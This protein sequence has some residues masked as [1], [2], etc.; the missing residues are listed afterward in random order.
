MFFNSIHY[1][2]FLP[3]V[4]AG[5]FLLPNKFRWGA[6]LAASY[7]FYMC[8]KIEYIILIV[9]S[10][11]VDYYAARAMGE[12]QEPSR[13][14]LLLTI[15]I[16][17]NLGILIAFKYFNFFSAST[18]ALFQHFNI[19]YDAPLFHVLLPVGISFYTFQTLSYTIE[20]YRGTQDP[21]KHLGIFALYVSFFP[22]LVAGPIERSTNLLP[23]FRESHS[24]NYDSAKSGAILIMWGLFKKVVVADRAAVIANHVFNNPGHYDGVQFAIGT[25][26]FAYQIYCD[27]SG[28]SDIAIGSAEI[29]GF[30]LMKNFDRPYYAKSIAEFWKRWHISL[31]TWFRDYLYIPLGGNRTNTVRR[32]ANLLITFII[33]GLW[34]GAAWTFVIWGALNGMYLILEVLARPMIVRIERY[35]R[36]NPDQ[37]AYKL[38]RVAITF[39]LTCFAWIFFRANNVSDAFYIVRRLDS[40]WRELFLAISSHNAAFINGLLRSLGLSKNE[41]LIT[42]GAIV[43][44]EIC[45]LLQRR[46]SGRAWL[47]SRPIAI[48]WA[49]YYA[50]VAGILFFGAFNQ[51]QQFIYFQF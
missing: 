9:I 14:R 42:A 40:G 41:L 17:S 34:H 6:L 36:F 47:R 30:R 18:R 43:F 46:G 50:L 33:S 1:A 49:F 12:T 8:W 25:V 10:T 3:I 26:F 21:E 15:S 24:F 32:Y 35:L 27:F 13:R 38:A 11:L 39:S 5:Y 4:V 31:S 28:Y 2:L 45:H 29:L 22:Q 37:P 20:V 51:S 7:Y 23:Q 19:F 44:L 48:R 16:I